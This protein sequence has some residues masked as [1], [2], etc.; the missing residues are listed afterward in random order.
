[1]PADQTQAPARPGA[2]RG[3]RLVAQDETDPTKAH[4]AKIPLAI[5]QC[6]TL[7]PTSKLAYAYLLRRWGFK[8]G[9]VPVRLPTFLRETGLGERALY[10]ALSQLVGA[11]LIERRQTGRAT[12]YRIPSIPSCYL[13][14]TDS[15]RTAVPDSAD[16]KESV[17]AGERNPCTTEY[18]SESYE[19]ASALAPRG[20]GE[21][22]NVP[23]EAM[24]HSTDEDRTGQYLLE[25]AGAVG[26]DLCEELQ[27]VGFV[28]VDSGHPKREEANRRA[29]CR[30]LTALADE[31]EVSDS[32][33]CLLREIRRIGSRKITEP[34]RTKIVSGLI[35][36]GIGPEMADVLFR[37]EEARRREEI[38]ELCL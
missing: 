9:W 36:H 8:K 24:P 13:K 20:T 26:D 14:G 5:L 31:V 22:L 32:V 15:A 11:G 25:A 38:D 33:D 4:F 21:T 17:S 2:R 30:R 18:M 19:T 7:R 16:T 6:S 37:H 29:L 10:T 28:L 27:K 3:G 12:R 35:H 23:S 1:M 34:E